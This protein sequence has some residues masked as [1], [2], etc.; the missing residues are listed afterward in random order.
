[1]VAAALCVTAAVA[2]APAAIALQAF[3]LSGAPD[4]FADLQAHAGAIGV[5]YPTYYECDPRNGELQGSADGEIDAYTAAHGIVELPRFTCQ[6]GAMVHR[7]LTNP[8]LRALT[9]ARLT[10]LA[11]GP[12]YG[13]I[14]LDLENDGP[15]DRGAL[16]LF[17][18]DLARRLHAERRRL[19]VDVVGVI[20]E[21]IP[22]PA[23]GFYNYRALSANGD[24]VFV[25][26][27]GTHWEGSAPGPLAPL[28]YVRG[29]ARFV[30]S[31]PY[32]RRFV[33]GVPLYGLDWSLAAHSARRAGALRPGVAR[34][35]SPRAPVAPGQAV[36]LQYAGVLALARVLGVTP[37]RDPASGE[38][39]FSYTREGVAHR[40]WYLDAR[41]AL[42]RIAI[43]RHY[44][45]AAGV[46]RLGEEDQSL[47]AALA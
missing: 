15:A 28:S 14:D 20:G 44:G 3:L 30:A 9:L 2:R 18:R 5:V 22:R 45:L 37:L 23:A 24:T 21:A 26:A 47:W 38:L 29:V 33:L 34:A 17:V 36:A 41:A 31:L 7:V 25:M 46:W 42:E 32:A 1:S 4:S 43:A 6:D 12:A 13:G 16:S 40:V 8:A 39:T 35:G 10:A 27:W 11:A 19:A